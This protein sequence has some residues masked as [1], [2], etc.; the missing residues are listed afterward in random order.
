MTVQDRRQL[1]PYR[2]RQIYDML[3]QRQSV[4][5]IAAAAKVSPNTVNR[6]AC[7][8]QMQG[9]KETGIAGLPDRELLERF[10]PGIEK[11]SGAAANTLNR[12][13][14]FIPD[15]AELTDR[16][17]ERKQTLKTAYAEYLAAAAQAGGEPLSRSYVYRRINW[18]LREL[19]AGDDY[20]MAQEHPYGQSCQ[21]D[22]SGSA[23][24]LSTHNGPVRVWIM[25]AAFP[26]SYYCYGQFVTAQSTEESC[27]VLSSLARKYNA[28]PGMVVCDNA[29]AWVVSHKS[30]D[31]VY[32]PAFLD[33]VSALGMYPVAA[34]PR[35]P[36][37][38]S[39]VEYSVNLIQRLA[40][41]LGLHFKEKK[42]LAG[43]NEFLQ[44]Q[45]DQ[46]INNGPLRGD[47]VRTRMYLF[48]TYE[49]PACHPVGDIPRFKGRHTTMVLPRSYLLKINGHSYSAPY[50]LI[51][52]SLDVFIGN[53]LVIIEFE[54]EEVARH[55]RCDN[56][57]RT[58][59]IQE[60]MPVEH[61]EIKDSARIFQDPD[62]TLNLA[63]SMDPWLYQLCAVRLRYGREHNSLS[64]ALASCRGL[65]G[66]YREETDKSVVSAA[67]RALLNLS[68][69]LWQT[70]NLRQQCRQL[71]AGAAVP[72]ASGA[73]LN[74]AGSSQAHLREEPDSTGPAGAEQQS[75]MSPGPDNTEKQ[76]DL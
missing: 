70:E 44:Q 74:R 7:M 36:Q 55:I 52:K 23:Y 10:Y 35:R 20:Y 65:I 38:K 8:A 59:V 9:L 43:H 66:V 14:S 11:D 49:L 50:R 73:R 51:H 64:N 71:K 63:Q 27:R 47:R 61:Q 41:G 42:T 15:F 72:K 29:R 53:D 25:V 33:F 22:F 3:Q 69:R 56:D 17:L 26:A 32:N 1:E 58:T 45:I 48:R 39:A 46:E 4:R 76:E 6:I 62:E 37:V 16:M 60:H 31:V 5:G 28:M 34:P 21:I 67:C 24:E 12:R 75:Q 40:A 30:T 54:G 68:P 57:G 2:I 13:N 19:K 18:R